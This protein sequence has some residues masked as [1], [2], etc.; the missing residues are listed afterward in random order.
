MDGGYG[1]TGGFYESPPAYPEEGGGGQGRGQ[2]GGQGGGLEHLL[3]RGIIEIEKRRNPNPNPN[4]NP[5]CRFYRSREEAW[6]V[7]RHVR[8]HRERRSAQQP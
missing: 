2:G 8:Y 3:A 4:P 5:D 1:G 7:G 6:T